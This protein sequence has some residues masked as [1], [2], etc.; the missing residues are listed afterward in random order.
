MNK[1]AKTLGLFVVFVALVVGAKFAYPFLTGNDSTNTPLPSAIKQFPRKTLSP[2]DA[3]QPFKDLGHECEVKWSDDPSVGRGVLISQSPEAGSNAGKDQK[4]TLVYGNGP[5]QAV[6]PDVRGMR[7]EQAWIKL[8]SLGM[9]QGISEQVDSAGVDQGS[10]VGYKTNK[11]GETLPR[12]TK[13][14]LLEASGFV[15]FPNLVG[16]DIKTAQV[17]AQ[18]RGLKLVVKMVSAPQEAGTV[19]KQS[20]DPGKSPAANSM[21]VQV[22][23]SFSSAGTEIPSML[24]LSQDDS[25]A[26]LR[27]AGFRNVKVIVSK[28]TNFA[29]NPQVSIAVSPGV[30]ELTNFAN[31]VT[32]TMSA[33]RTD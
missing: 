13:I 33:L 1:F 30:G 32:I 4:V 10:V 7:V 14:N 26:A 27:A 29:A 15:D 9:D 22:A 16:T 11:V 21:E 5:A 3:C 6:L 23:R 24:G 17:K 2:Y 31:T 20:P 28:D 18:Q 12:G 8:Y 25:I 19:V